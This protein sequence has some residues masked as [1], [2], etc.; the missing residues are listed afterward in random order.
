MLSYGFRMDKKTKTDVDLSH[1]G[2]TTVVVTFIGL[3]KIR[4]RERVRGYNQ[5]DGT[6]LPSSFIIITR[7][8]WKWEGV[9]VYTR[10]EKEEQK[11][12]KNIFIN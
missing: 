10:E 8:H 7:Y 11:K 3:Q 6:A 2:N 12:K 5:I 1:Q 4:K 9:S